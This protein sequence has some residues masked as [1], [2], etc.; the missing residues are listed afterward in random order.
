MRS[1]QNVGRARALSARYISNCL[2]NVKATLG[3]LGAAMTGPLVGVLGSATRQN[4]AMRTFIVPTEYSEMDSGTAMCLSSLEESDMAPA[5]NVS[6]HRQYQ[7]PTQ[8]QCE[9][10]HCLG[11]FEQFYNEDMRICHAETAC[12]AETRIAASANEA[13]SGWLI[14]RSGCATT[15]ETAHNLTLRTGSG[16]HIA[17]RAELRQAGRERSSNQPD[18]A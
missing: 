16:S 2:G 5:R 9:S 14:P 11:H 6:R 3:D 7:C 4:I 10:G 8:D 15:L 1:F 18:A 12:I 17:I 13:R